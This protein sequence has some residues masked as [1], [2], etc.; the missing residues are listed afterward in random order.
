MSTYATA[1]RSSSF[2]TG[3]KILAHMTDSSLALLDPSEPRL[4]DKPSPASSSLATASGGSLSA[5]D[6]KG[7]HTKALKPD[8]RCILPLVEKALDGK[9]PERI[10]KALQVAQRFDY[11]PFEQV[12]KAEDRKEDT[13]DLRIVL[14]K[15]WARVRNDPTISQ[16]RKAELRPLF[17]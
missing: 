2:R 14:E 5:R 6:K 12:D 4:L 13:A 3:L 16:S 8:S 7:H 15:A 10:V 9:D 1:I 11:L 17:L